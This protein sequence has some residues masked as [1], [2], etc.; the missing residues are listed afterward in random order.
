[1]ELINNII[2]VLR[3]IFKMG[4]QFGLFLMFLGLLIATI[5]VISSLRKSKL[6][7]FSKIN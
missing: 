7:F 3:V 6:K 2:I 5:S 1:M 4:F